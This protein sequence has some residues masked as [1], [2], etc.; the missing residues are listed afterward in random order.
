LQFTIGDDGTLTNERE[1]RSDGLFISKV[2]AIHTGEDASNRLAVLMD[3]SSCAF[4]INGQYVGSYLA[5]DL[6]HAGEVG[7]YVESSGGLETF[8]DL[9]ISP[10]PVNA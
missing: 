4:F 9:L 10:P 6:P 2:G 7:I 5:S 1:L 3:G 8:S